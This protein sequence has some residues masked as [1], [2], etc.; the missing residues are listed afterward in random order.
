V[1]QAF[2]KKGAFLVWSGCSSRNFFV[3]IRY[4]ETIINEGFAFKKQQEYQMTGFP[5]KKQQESQM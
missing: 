5:F 2:V 4:S 3:N 1:H